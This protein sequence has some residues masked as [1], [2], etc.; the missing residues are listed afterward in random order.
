MVFRIT[1]LVLITALA[2]SGAELLPAGKAKP[3]T[4]DLA[5]Q[6]VARYQAGSLFSR[7]SSL[8]ILWIENLTGEGTSLEKPL[9]LPDSFRVMI[10]DVAVSF[11]GMLAASVSATDR[12]GS[13]FAAIAWLKPDG[14]LIRV[15]RT[16]PFGA[17]KISFT[18]DG[19]LW[20]MG[21]LKKDETLRE[22]EPVHDLLR[23]YG[24]DGELL[25]TY[26]P[27][28][29]VSSGRPHPSQGGLLVTSRERV[30]FVSERAGKWAVL[31]AD[32]STL[33]QGTLSGPEGY[34]IFVAAITD[35]GRLFVHGQ[36]RSGKTPAA[37]D[38]PRMPL[39]EIDQKSGEFQLVETTGAFAEG[40]SGNLVGADGEQ[41]VFTAETVR[42]RQI[43]W[44]RAD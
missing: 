19:S 18:A 15:V 6:P 36:W 7:D 14:S 27:R 9:T 21:I 29:S 2:G 11:N 12:E 1:I 4:R 39:F 8:S 5:M 35:S 16:T 25:G 13:P 17:G 38:R 10:S 41:L 40:E 44:M 32:G 31:G 34:R 37:Q 43:K 30:G 42:D 26:L 3:F 28:L 33:G 24:A 23:R 22:E 20:A